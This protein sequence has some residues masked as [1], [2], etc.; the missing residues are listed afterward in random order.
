M[1]TSYRQILSIS[2][3]IMLG[4][5]VQNVIASTDAVFL[6]HLGEYDFAAIGF[7]GVF[8]LVVAA[9]GY[10]F[11]RGGQILIARRMGEGRPGDIGPVFYAMLYYELALALFM[12]L[13]MRYGCSY[14]FQFM[15]N[16]PIIIEKS[17][18]YLDYR[19]W[20]V[21][22]SYLGVALIALYSGVGRTVFIIVVTLILATVNIL[23]DYAL[24]F[25]HWGMPAMGIAGAGLASAI[26]ELVAFVVFV[27]Y[28]LLDQKA[29]VY[30]LFQY[31]KPN[32]ALIRQQYSISI[33]MV[34][35]AIIGL[36]SVLV[37]V[38]FVEKL[39][40]RELAINQLVRMV[41]LILSIPCW[42]FS[43][44]INTLVSNLI[45]QR[46]RG[47]VLPVVRRTAWLSL[48][49]TMALTL[50]IVLAPEALLYPLLGGADMSLVTEARPVFNLLPAIMTSFAVGGVFFNGLIGTGA[51][52]FGLKVQGWSVAGYVIYIYLAIHVFDG[53]LV[54]AWAAELFYW[55]AMLLVALWYLRSDRWHELRL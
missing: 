53:G 12:F 36:G 45:G 48:L 17:M 2:T 21:F 4:S 33:P 13:F 3:P 28:I 23:L 39:G 47:G 9:I 30:R 44:G 37:F 34:L 51:T 20:G 31:H 6:Y 22:F 40:E 8:Y 16:S 18:I 46:K 7:V 52:L 50:P 29:R 35:Q 41:Y 38:S 43:S 55:A 15:L 10:G 19:S 27:L 5:A 25:G 26:A 42:G 14:L 24:V 32:L 49:F 54:W 1:N 11:S